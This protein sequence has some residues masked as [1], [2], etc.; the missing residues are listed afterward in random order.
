MSGDDVGDK[1]DVDVDGMMT[2]IIMIKMVSM[3][4]SMVTS[5]W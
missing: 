4:S 1:K 5:S 3:I 2:S